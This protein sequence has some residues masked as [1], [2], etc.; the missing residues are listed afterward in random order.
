MKADLFEEFIESKIEDIKKDH[1]SSDEL[2]HIQLILLKEIIDFWREHKNRMY[3][4]SGLLV[5]TSVNET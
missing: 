5:P 3:S 4:H 1:S 2:G